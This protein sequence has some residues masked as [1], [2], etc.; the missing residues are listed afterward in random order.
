MRARLL[1]RLTDEGLAELAPGVDTNL[2]GTALDPRL[3]AADQADLAVLL[4]IGQPMAVFIARPRPTTTR[5]PC[6]RPRERASHRGA[7][8]ERHRD[9]GQAP[10]RVIPP[11]WA[12]VTAVTSAVIVI[13]AASRDRQRL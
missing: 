8:A 12:L 1:E 4:D 7:A 2:F 6:D 11:A 9:R 3:S 5:R 10:T 13:A